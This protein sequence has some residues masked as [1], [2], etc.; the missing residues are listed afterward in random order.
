MQITG[1]A[2]ENKRVVNPEKNWT[3]TM[4]SRRNSFVASGV[5]AQPK[6]QQHKSCCFLAPSPATAHG[7]Y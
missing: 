4:K 1:L 3:K 6:Q 5:D 2:Q 7:N